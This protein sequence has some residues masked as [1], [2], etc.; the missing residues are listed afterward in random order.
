MARFDAVVIGGGPAGLSAAS[1]LATQGARTVLLDE[2]A[3][4]GGQIYRAIEGASPALRTLLGEDYTCGAWLVDRL[5]ASGAEWRPGSAVWQVTPDREVWVSR[6]GSSE[7]LRADVVMVA[8]GAIERPVPVPGWTLPGAMTCG[9]VQILLKTSGLVA[10]GA[11]LAGSGPLLYLVAAQCIAAGAR[12]A[13]ILDTATRSNARAARRHLPRALLGSV[14]R[15]TL[16]KGF[17]LQA[18]IR[19][20]GTEWFRHV[21]DLSVEGEAA[22]EAVRFTCHGREQRIAT[23]LVALHE[24]II[25]NQQITRSLGCAHQWDAAQRCF[26]PALDDWGNTSVPGILVAGDGGG[27]VGARAAGHA[28]RIAAAEALA[29]LGRLDAAARD[30]LAEPDRVGLAAQRMVRPFLDA[31]FAPPAWVLRPADDV[32]VCRCEEVRAGAVRDVVAQGCLGPN[33]AKSFLRAGMG[34]CQGRMCGPVVSELIAEAR[35]VGLDEVGYFRIRPPLKPVTVG[36][37]AGVT[38]DAE[39]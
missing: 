5:R 17:L 1:L 34:P 22:V 25:P 12:P 16:L 23:G 27:I 31:L 18:Q 37:L 8:T 3:A 26:R 30:R 14:G 38:L 4:P 28:G 13:A 20:S 6:E 24:G 11:V 39:A 33:Q 32:V 9:A 15:A 29:Q 7:L 21:T 36:E 19:A 10:E 2:Q 35:G